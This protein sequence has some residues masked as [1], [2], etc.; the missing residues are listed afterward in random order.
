MPARDAP[1]AM[2]NAISR[3]RPL[4]RTSSKFATLLQ[5]MSK[6][7]VTAANSVIKPARKFSVTSSGSVFAVVVSELS[8]L[9]GY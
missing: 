2:R 7:N 8:I 5:A 3:R 9:F 6:T 1:I 4:K